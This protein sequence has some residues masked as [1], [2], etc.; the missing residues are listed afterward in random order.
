MVGVLSETQ[1][2][3]SGKALSSSLSNTKK[4]EE[5]K[6]LTSWRHLK[7]NI[8]YARELLSNASRV[9]QIVITSC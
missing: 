3:I 4:E 2:C 5:W 8:V 1:Q 9:A 6:N 7:K